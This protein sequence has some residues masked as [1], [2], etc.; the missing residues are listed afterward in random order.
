M[1]DYNIFV[2]KNLA[3]GAAYPS[4]KLFRRSTC[5]QVF[6]KQ[7]IFTDGQ[8]L[9]GRASDGYVDLGLSKSVPSIW[10]S[11][12]VE[13]KTSAWANWMLSG[14]ST[15]KDESIQSPLSIWQAAWYQKGEVI[16]TN[17]WKSFQGYTKYNSVWKIDVITL[18][19]K[20][21]QNTNIQRSIFSRRKHRHKIKLSVEVS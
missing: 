2:C 8:G 21:Y 5:L 16:C 10:A 17:G 7:V 4:Y 3:A 20:Q 15:P 13:K 1:P 9:S 18:L 11:P 19:L 12:R 14:R 6:L